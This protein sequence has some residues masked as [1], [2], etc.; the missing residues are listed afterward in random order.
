MAVLNCTPHTVA[1]YPE[2]A[3]VRL[4]QTNPTSWVADGIKGAPLIEYPSHGVIRIATRINPVKLP[5]PGTHVQ[6]YYGE[7]EGIPATATLED[8]LIVS[9]PT[10]SMA[11]QAGHPLASKMLA[12]HKVVRNRANTSEVLGCMGFSL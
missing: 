11:R 3:F 2:S 5:I 6:T 12:P 1:V 10:Q 8:W 4:E 9:L 7:V